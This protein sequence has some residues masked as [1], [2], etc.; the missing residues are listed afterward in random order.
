LLKKEFRRSD[1]LMVYTIV[2]Q[3]C[4]FIFT[5]IRGWQI[6]GRENMPFQ[7]GVVVV[8][9]H[10]SLWDSLII[11]ATFDRIVCFM[12]KEELYIKNF[13]FTWFIKQLHTF[14][15]KRGKTDRAAIKYALDILKKGGILGLFPEGTRSQSGDLQEARNGAAM[16]AIKTGV[17][18]LPVG[19]IGSK[20]WG[21]MIVNV[22]KPIDTS[23]FA[24][25]KLSKESMQVL[26]N[27]F[28]EQI[29]HLTQ[30]VG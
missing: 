22:G 24:S 1:G 27:L 26:S 11:G 25:E 2:H 14:P 15:I 4:R 3:I 10:T 19:I 28:M 9:N 5:F 6:N 8:S 29:A 23:K 13:L 7:G 12:G 21:R 16:L 30:K 17:P 20:G 18:V